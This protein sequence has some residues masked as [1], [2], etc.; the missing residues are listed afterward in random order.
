[1]TTIFRED[2]RLLLGALYTV[3][4]FEGSLLSDEAWTSLVD[5]FT[6]YIKAD[7]VRCD[8]DGRVDERQLM[9]VEDAKNM[10]KVLCQ[11][12]T[13][14]HVAHVKVNSI[15]KEVFHVGDNS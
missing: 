3:Q 5:Y 15:A 14:G 4:A 9:A 7:T 12:Q 1:M 10:T 8:T 2:V 11:F 6:S 13:Y